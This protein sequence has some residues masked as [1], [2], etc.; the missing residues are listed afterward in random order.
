MSALKY[1]RRLHR[2]KAISSITFLFLICSW[3]VLQTCSAADNGGNGYASTQARDTG[4]MITAG[5]ALFL[6]AITTWRFIR[7]YDRG[8]FIEDID[9]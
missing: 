2:Q 4:Y 3:P 7:D 9:F 8:F 6:L 1:F 5:V